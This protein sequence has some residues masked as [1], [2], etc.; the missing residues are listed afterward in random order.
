MEENLIS[1]HI[2]G[3]IGRYPDMKEIKTFIK[4]IPM[5]DTLIRKVQGKD[6]VKMSI[7]Y[8]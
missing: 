6:S 4:N 8:I 2:F 5:L 7:R 1:S 3:Y